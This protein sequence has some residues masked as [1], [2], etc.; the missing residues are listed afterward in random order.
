MLRGVPIGFEH[1]AASQPARQIKNVIRRLDRLRQRGRVG[2]FQ[3][4]RS[5]LRVHD[6]TA[7]QRLANRYK[8]IDLPIEFNWQ[9]V[10]RAQ[11]TVES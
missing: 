11:V 2:N 5:D 8:T 10:T 4:Q 1:T 7:T 9:T 6:V 3:M